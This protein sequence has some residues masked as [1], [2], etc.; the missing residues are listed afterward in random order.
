MEFWQDWVIEKSWDVLTKIKK[1]FD[2][3]LVGGWVAIYIL[4][5]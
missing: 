1:E 5:L 3:V 2:F 4:L